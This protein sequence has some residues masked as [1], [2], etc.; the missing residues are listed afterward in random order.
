M[1]F[2]SKAALAALAAAAM[3]SAGFTVSDVEADADSI[4]GV[5][6]CQSTADS[7][8]APARNSI[9]KLTSGN[10]GIRVEW[11]ADMSALGYQI[12]Y[13]QDKSFKTYHSTTVKDPA[14]TYVNLTNVPRA[15][16]TWYVKVRSFVTADGSFTSARYGTYSEVRSITTYLNI[17]KVTIPYISYTYSGKE[18]RPTVKVK[19]SKGNI[20]PAGNYTA[21][22]SNNVNVGIAKITVTGSGI[23]KGTYVKEFYVKPA[24]NEI[25]SLTTAKGA[26]KLSWKAGTPGTVGYQVLYSTTSDFSD[27]VHSYTSTVLNDLTENFS[28]V[29]RAGETWYVKVRSFF[30]RDGLATSTRYGNYSAVKSITTANETKNITK[31]ANVYSTAAFSQ[32]PIGSVSAGTAVSILSQSGRWYKISYGALTGWVYNKAFGVTSNASGKLNETTVHAF[33]DDVI[34]DIGTSAKAINQ[35]VMSHVR[36]AHL[37]AP[38]TERDGTAA[39]AF[40]Y[41]QAACYHFAAAADILLE[42]AGYTHKIVKGHSTT[43]THHWNIYMTPGGWRYMDTTPFIVY[44]SG[45]YDFTGDQVKTIRQFTWDRAAY[46]N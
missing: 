20:I 11:N 26:F 2:A 41:H 8:A 28:K 21:V 15:G 37:A 12:L 35:Y 16:E 10:G 40:T 33:A 18:I 25:T 17:D 19:D 7:P 3:A 22:Y 14:R 34:F 1:N 44:P 45:F 38:I 46:E 9:T 36:Y 5:L 43:D 39:Y 30:T 32:S 24:R 29:P 4:S 6:V 23:A 13:S 31:A 42:H 27:N